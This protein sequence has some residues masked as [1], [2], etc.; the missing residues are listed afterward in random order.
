MELSP[1]VYDALSKIQSLQC[2]HVR[3]DIA[4]ITR[5]INIPHPSIPLG[6]DFTQQVAGSQ[7][8][9]P[10]PTN[11]GPYPPPG[12][13]K[14]VIALNKSKLMKMRVERRRFGNFHDL[15]ALHITAIDSL[16]CLDQIRLCLA[17]S[18]KT[19]RLLSL[20]LSH[21]LVKKARKMP[22]NSQPGPPAV[23]PMDD[24]EGVTEPT[25]PETNIQAPAAPNDAD[26][27]KER[28]EQ[29]S[30]LARVFGFEKPAIEDKKLDRSL[31]A[32]AKSVKLTP[33]ESGQIEKLKR[34]LSLIMKSP[35][36]N[37]LDA[38]D[39]QEI[40]KTLRERLDKVTLSK[41]SKATSKPK[42]AKKVVT[43]KPKQTGTAWM[44]TPPYPMPPEIAHWDS[45]PPLPPV[46]STGD[47]LPKTPNTYLPYTSSMHKNGPAVSDA[48]LF[49]SLFGS[50]N[51]AIGDVPGSSQFLPS[52][53]SQ[54]SNLNYNTTNPKPSSGFSFGIPKASHSS[55]P[56]QFG[57]NAFPSSYSGSV[58]HSPYDVY[59]H[60]TPQALMQKL[61]QNHLKKYQHASNQTA[62]YQK[63]A[64]VAHQNNGKPTS[65]TSTPEDLAGINSDS[66]T[67]SSLDELEKTNDITPPNLPEQTNGILNQE[68]G[69]DI[70]V[71]MEHP[72]IAGESDGNDAG[73]EAS[74]MSQDEGDEGV[75][76]ASKNGVALP[77]AVDPLLKENVPPSNEV[78]STND[79][80]MDSRKTTST[81]AFDG[82]GEEAKSSIFGNN[83]S[84]ARPPE[85]IMQEYIRKTHGF[86]VE[87][88]SLYLVPLKP[89]VLAKA[90]NLS[91]LRR[92]EFYSVGP[93]GAFWTMLEK[94]VEQG[95][96]SALRVIHTDDVSTAFVRCISKLNSL[97]QLHLMRRS[98]KEFDSTTSKAPATI[99]EI[100]K[101]A[102]L[103]HLATLES[104]S[105]VNNEDDKWDLNGKCLHLLA[106]KGKKLRELAC[107][108]DTHNF[109]SLQPL[110]F[111]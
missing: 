45:L 105:I 110:H 108:M 96:E 43:K 24:D 29:E 78:T 3:L 35:A 66:D 46:G 25:T 106:A 23:D 93:Q 92:V 102:L 64:N 1:N 70:D 49:N 31:K 95:S 17:Q 16:D 26:I 30:T 39:A 37:E 86:S 63:Y 20:S 60:Y 57:N 27:K 85:D 14:N 87:E 53:S 56:P 104:L 109:V 72:D 94:L 9:P 22:S 40:V 81:N 32:A 84:I 80:S 21:S 99:D 61:L 34:Q 36:L 74:G 77:D 12:S 83:V 88:L 38:C 48:D 11:T 98:T 2:L 69:P 42:P 103:K 59:Y 5:P 90:L 55:Q 68:S 54:A 58:S 101:L 62:W 10:I 47:P 4:S 52:S 67:S 111:R 107:S 50:G 51:N 18:S 7:Y 44:S 75:D 13:T 28:K 41:A 73:S 79:I 6:P 65:Q 100:R 8:F 71:D 76:V 91:C 82:A 15:R 19:V 33:T 89:S 97:Q